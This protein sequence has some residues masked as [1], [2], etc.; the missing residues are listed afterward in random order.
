M[1]K[2][3]KNSNKREKKVVY[4]RCDPENGSE[5]YAKFFF[6]KVGKENAIERIIN[7]CYIIG[8]NNVV[9]VAKF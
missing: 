2:N 6:I 5:K 3:K 4:F 9:M 1:L 8:E 7:R